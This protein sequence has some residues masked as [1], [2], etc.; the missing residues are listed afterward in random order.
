MAAIRAGSRSLEGSLQRLEKDLR[1]PLPRPRVRELATLA[2]AIESLAGRLAG[3]GEKERALQR[4]LSQQERLGALG[5]VV[6]GVA[7]EIRNPLAAIKLRLDLLERERRLD[8]VGAEDV[9]TAQAE[10]AR[11][12]RL[13]VQILGAARRGAGASVP[14]E[15]RPLAVRR[16]DSA[17]AAASERG[18]TLAVAGDGCALADPDLVTQ[19]LDN[20]I[21]NAMEASPRGAEVT[22]RCSEAESAARIDVEDAGPGVGPEREATLFE[23][24]FTTKP[25]GTGLGLW[26]SRTAVEAAGGKLTYAREGAVTRMRIEL[27]RRSEP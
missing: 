24:F 9:R 2:A 27:P 15:L 7:H 13:V 14:V 3:A 17:R 22:V 6:A 8:P 20:L 4:Q 1:A 10:L 5:R 23:P 18:V 25:D 12:D 11:L 16:I 21:R 19:A 26:L